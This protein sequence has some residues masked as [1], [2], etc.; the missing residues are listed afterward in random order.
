MHV[1]KSIKGKILGE[2]QGP[3]SSAKSLAFSVKE[4]CIPLQRA[5]SLLQKSPK[6]P[7]KSPTF[8]QK[9]PISLQKGPEYL[10]KQLFQLCTKTHVPLESRG[11]SKR[12]VI[13]NE[14]AKIAFWRARLVAFFKWY[15]CV[16]AWRDWFE[17]RGLFACTWLIYMRTCIRRIEDI[18]RYIYMYIYIYM[19]LCMCVYIHTYVYIYICIY[20]SI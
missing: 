11:P 14:S 5:F 20:I 12:Q 13:K 7:W 16:C 2:Q 18:Q 10:S 8:P 19:C 17:W 15:M 1:T 9:P 4:P 3:V 6:S